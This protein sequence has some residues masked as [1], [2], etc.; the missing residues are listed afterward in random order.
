LNKKELVRSYIKKHRYFNLAEVVKE[1][2]L[3]NQ[4]AKNYLYTLKSEGIVFSAGRGVYSS[5][6]QEFHPQEKSR[7]IEIR[8]LL[9]KQFPELDFLIWNTLYFQPYYHHQQ[10]HNI[11][12]VEVEADAMRPVADSI[13]RNYR[14]VMIEKASRV[15]PKGFDITRDPI[16]VRLL[17]K[18]SPR[19][20]H[21]PSLEKML[22]D[23]FVVKDKYSTMSDGDYWELWRSIDDFFRVNVSALI[24]YAQARRYFQD[25]V[26][27]LI[28]N[29]G[30][31]N[32]T[33]GSYLKY[34]GKVTSNKGAHGKANT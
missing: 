21:T 8:Q 4:V 11:T 6:A 7:V 9:K 12:F 10:T 17:I 30:L 33:F 34:A 22:V 19:K 28:D 3:S 14:F 15:V 26:S 31:N 32:V 18:D 5:V 23:L 13:S 20:G 25:I 27:Q 2:G 29:V 1:T 24:A 16:V